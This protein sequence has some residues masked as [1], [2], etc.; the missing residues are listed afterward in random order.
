MVWHRGMD[1]PLRRL[2]SQNIPPGE[3]L[4]RGSGVRGPLGIWADP[5]LYPLR[6]EAKRVPEGEE[7]TECEMRERRRDRDE[8]GVGM[9][10]PQSRRNRQT[11]NSKER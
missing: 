4:W 10:A 7:E 5:Y 8:Q 11:K 9:R 1:I 3:T 2:T 6:A